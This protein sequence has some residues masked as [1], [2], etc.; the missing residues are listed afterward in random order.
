[1]RESFEITGLEEFVSYTFKVIVATDVGSNPPDLSA[2]GCVRTEAAGEH[3][4]SM[5]IHV[6]ATF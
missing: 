3:T 5:Y 4:H 1:M 6:H 2:S